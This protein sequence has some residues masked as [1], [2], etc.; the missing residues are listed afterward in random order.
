MVAV[1]YTQAPASSWA[2]VQGSLELPLGRLAP[3]V[4]GAGG[5]L[6]GDG[7][8]A[9]SPV[10]YAQPTVRAWLTSP[11][12]AAL[13][14]VAGLGLHVEDQVRLLASVGAA[15]DTAPRG[16]TRPRLEATYH[17]EAGISRW[18]LGMAAGLVFGKPPPPPVLAEEPE[19]IPEEPAP[20]DLGT[21]GMV[22]V[23]APVCDWLEPEELAAYQDVL[24]TTVRDRWGRRPAGTPPLMLPPAPTTVLVAAWPGDDV[25]VND[26]QIP[27]D[28]QGFG[29]FR[30]AS[31]EARIQV[32]GGGRE[33]LLPIEVA[34]EHALWMSVDVPTPI[35]IQFEVN[36][37]TLNEASL[38]QI[39]AVV[40]QQGGWGFEVR[41]SHSPE[42]PAARNETLSRLRAQ[43]VF[44]AILAAG[45]DPTTVR[46]S[47]GLDIAESADPPEYLRAAVIYPVELP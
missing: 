12:R 3:G 33:L 42:G 23:P 20:P 44:A 13:S 2:G 9:G 22:W 39:E 17:W 30:L 38:A 11:D 15:L 5:I 16:R 26:V 28:E 37:A 10:L 14:A 21:T 34:D 8:A 40:G 18:R 43:A 24:P 4:R 29:K 25:W 1:A 6:Y 46:L 27:L 47:E 41:G 31:P 36:Q 35:R 45:A 32:Q 19:P 7:D